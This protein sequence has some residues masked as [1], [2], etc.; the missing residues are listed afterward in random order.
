[1]LARFLLQQMAADPMERALQESHFEFRG[2]A[3]DPP[4]ANPRR[5]VED[6]ADET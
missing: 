1:V 2:G 5:R 3:Q 6:R 4:R